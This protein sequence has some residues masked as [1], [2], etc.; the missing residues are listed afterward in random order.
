MNFITNHDENS[1]NGTVFE[2]LGDAVEVYAFLT[3]TVPGMP[4]IYSGQ[5]NGL[6]KRLKFFTKDTIHWTENKW[7]DIYSDFI[8]VKKEN[9]ALWN[10]SYGGRM[11]IMETEA[12][13]IFAFKRVDDENEIIAITNLSDSL[14]QVNL[15]FDTEKYNSVLGVTGYELSQEFLLGAYEYMLLVKND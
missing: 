4:L 3:F 7:Q 9:K 5:E 10:G 11:E 1:W 2:R 8:R 15:D 14:L 6:N 13:S 12:E